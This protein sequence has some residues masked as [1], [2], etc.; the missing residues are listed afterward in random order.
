VYMHWWGF[1]LSGWV[2][3]YLVGGGFLGW[4]VFFLY[5][6]PYVGEFNIVWGCGAFGPPPSD[7]A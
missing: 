4:E 6:F 7:G 3:L 2:W 1:N 5:G